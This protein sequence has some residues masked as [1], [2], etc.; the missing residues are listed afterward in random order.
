MEIL[1]V[2][3]GLQFLGEVDGLEVL[4]RDWGRVVKNVVLLAVEVVVRIVL[5]PAHESLVLRRHSHDFLDAVGVSLP[6]SKLILVLF[7]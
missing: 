5:T 7:A 3:V 1:E 4:P 2:V 6:E